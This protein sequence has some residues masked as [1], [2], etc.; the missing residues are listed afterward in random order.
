MAAMAGPDRSDWLPGSVTEIV[1]GWDE[2]GPG[3]E[4][5]PG[6]G[7]GLMTGLVTAHV[8]TAAPMAPP[9]SV[10]MRATE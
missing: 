6:P 5:E 10:A 7:P 8:K 9:L 3:P 1:F 2:P 4:P